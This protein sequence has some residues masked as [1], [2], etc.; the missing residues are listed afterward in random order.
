VPQ[1]E[2]TPIHHLYPTNIVYFRNKH[3]DIPTKLLHII[4][5]QEFLAHFKTQCQI[6]FS[7]SPPNT[8]YFIILSFSAE[9]MFMF[10]VKHLQKFTKLVRA[11]L[12]CSARFRQDLNMV[13]SVVLSPAKR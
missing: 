10:F 13:A 4:R 5:Q 3:R 12:C 6:Y 1:A 2:V 9:T 8:V 11:E 7:L